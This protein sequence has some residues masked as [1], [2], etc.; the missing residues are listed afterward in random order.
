[1]ILPS[2]IPSA[3]RSPLRRRRATLCSSRST[4]L[5]RSLRLSRR[6]SFFSPFLYPRTFLSVSP[7]EPQL[8]N[9]TVRTSLSLSDGVS[10]SRIVRA[11]LRTPS[12]LTSSLPLASV[13]SRPVHRPGVKESPSKRLSTFLPFLYSFPQFH[14]V[15]ALSTL[16]RCITEWTTD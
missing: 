1:M 12:L 11:R 4:R 14:F 15:C 2:Q 3:S 5:E 16:L 8:M 9:A 13:R 6:T 7:L 10:W